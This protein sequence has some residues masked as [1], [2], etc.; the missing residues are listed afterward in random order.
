VALLA[1]RDRRSPPVILLWLI[2]SPAGWPA[3][4]RYVSAGATD[5][6]RMQWVGWGFGG[7]EAVLVV[8]ALE[9]GRAIRTTP[10]WAVADQGRAARPDRQHVPA[11][12]RRVDRPSPTPSRWPG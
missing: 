5:R 9:L 8:I 2:A 12:R 7:R 1:N 4:G 3:H 11:G 10:A 6:R